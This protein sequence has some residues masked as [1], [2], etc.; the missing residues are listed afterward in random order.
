MGN[1]GDW[2]KKHR[3]QISMHTNEKRPICTPSHV[4]WIS[5]LVVAKFSYLATTAFKCLQGH[6]IT[7]SMQRTH[8]LNMQTSLL[9]A[10]GRHVNLSDLEATAL[11]ESEW[12]LSECHC[13]LASTSG[14]N[15]LVIK[16]GLFV[17]DKVS[18]VESPNVDRLVKVAVNLYFL[19]DAS[20]DGIVAEWNAANGRDEAMPSVVPNHLAALSHSELCSVV[21]THQECL[22]ATG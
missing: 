5:L 2:F 18:L 20:V 17:I 12:V 3:I 4:W 22:V 13:F 6:Y 9:H 15:Q 8:L 7:V 11:D 16:L 14:A 1:V 21:R 19:Y 10:V